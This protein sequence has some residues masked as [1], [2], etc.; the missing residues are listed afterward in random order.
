MA[1]TVH[2]FGIRHHGPGSARSVRQ[3][4]E[5]LQPDVI[6]VEGPPDGETVLPLLSHPEMKPPVAMLLYVPETPRRA[7][8][9]PFAVFSPEWQAIHFGLTNDIPVRFMDLPQANQLAMDT[10]AETP[11][12]PEPLAVE[13]LASE[14]N[15]IRRDPLRALAEA[16]GYSDSERW[17]EHMVEQR[18]GGEDV[19]AAINEAMTALRDEAGPDPDPREPKRE[20]YM[21]QTIRAAQREGHEK[22]AVVCGAWHAPALADLGD[23]K[24][25]KA[26]LADMPKTKI[27]ATWVPWTNS[28]LSYHSGYGAGIESPGWY[29]HLWVHECDIA[30]RWMTR[31]AHLLRAE[32]LDASPAHIIEAVRLAETLTA[33]RGRPL[34]GLPEMNEATQAVFCFGSDLPLRLISEKL[35]VGEALG[36]VPSETPAIPLQR[37]LEALQRRLRLPRDAAQKTLDLD[38]RNETDLARSHLLHR[39]NLLSIPWGK[40]ERATG[41]KGTFHELWRIQWQPEFAVAVIDAG[42]WGNTVLDAAEALAAD[43]SDKAA[44]LP[45]LT[46]LLDRVMF[47]ELPGAV[48]RLMDRLEEQAA[49]ASDVAHLMGA[50]PPLVNVMR[51]GNVRRTDAGMVRHVVD[52][53]VT[54]IAVGLPAACASLSDEAAAAMYGHINAVQSAIVLIEDKEQLATWQQTL[55]R[56]AESDTLHGLLAG[57]CCRILRDSGVFDAD[58][59]ARRLGLALSTASD[60]A[61]AAAWAEGFLRG[62]G[63]ILLLDEGLWS[64]VDGWVSS[65]RPE[66]FPELLPLLR[67]TFSTFTVPER[68]QMGERVRHGHAKPVAGQGDEAFDIERAEAVLPLVGRLLGVRMNMS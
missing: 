3:A 5:R 51:Y 63:Q 65:L 13:T 64:V 54:R 8:Y 12:E 17:W 31:V 55:I 57:R 34:P 23:A 24:G 37:D 20:A 22:I 9:Y 68:R 21:R 35:I 53:L 47:A 48:R 14:T 67:R 36:S 15:S 45:A 61:R 18:R 27:A 30:T 29:Q 58:E 66:A 16:A 52:G 4:L 39:L 25:D 56:L 28:R 60:P 62:S 11:A 32:D 1:S 42:L 33:L 2:I 50:L 19:F 10:D 40:G 41:G 46:A 6:L 26:L 7:V 59:S 44:D 49:L 43:Q 38:L